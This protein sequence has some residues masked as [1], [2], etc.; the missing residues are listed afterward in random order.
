[1]RAAGEAL[2]VHAAMATRVGLRFASGDDWLAARLADLGLVKRVLL[3]WTVEEY[4]KL[5]LLIEEDD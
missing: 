5:V 1:M 4:H 2:E 3:T